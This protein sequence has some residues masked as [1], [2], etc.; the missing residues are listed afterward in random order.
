MRVW[1]L[2]QWCLAPWNP[3]GLD[4]R[5]GE[6]RSHGGYGLIDARGRERDD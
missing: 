3:E 5:D 4:R 2:A 6:R 1:R